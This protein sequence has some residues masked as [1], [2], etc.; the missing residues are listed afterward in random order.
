MEYFCK[1]TPEDMAE[2]IDFLNMVF[3]QS[4]HPH[5]FKAMLPKLYGDDADTARYHYI[6][7]E[8][9]R[10]K[11]VVGVFPTEYHIGDTLVKVGQLGSVSVHPYARGK[12]YMKRL[13]DWA[14]EDSQAQGY[15][16]L[17]LG[18]LKNRYQHFGFQPTEIELNY[19]FIPEN[20]RHQLKDV[21]PDHI[22][23]KSVKD[24]SD[25][26]IEKVFR[27]CGSQRVYVERGDREHFFK[28]LESWYMET[29]I[30]EIDDEFSGYLCASADGT[31]IREW[32]MTSQEAYMPVLKRHFEM[33][34]PEAVSIS[35]AAYER[36]KNE[37]FGRYSEHCIVESGHQWRIFN[38]EKILSAMMKVKNSYMPLEEGRLEIRI[39]NG[40]DETLCK[41]KWGNPSDEKTEFM[42]ISLLEAEEAFFSEAGI[43]RNYGR[44]A[45]YL[46]KNW[47]PLPLYTNELDAC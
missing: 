33:K 8:E 13:M 43:Y 11:A 5:D 37:I 45:G 12:N 36:E 25:E 38:F 24:A 1:A 22:V 7:K 23:F 10:I 3:S 17:V 19:K 40:S 46:Y 21:R 20:I 44:K 47:F 42:D 32:L 2:L 27:L 4:S 6:V 31:W 28:V 41:L 35:C 14:I 34:C 9:G 30:V 26:D 16:A 15:D 39:H 18:G 29:W